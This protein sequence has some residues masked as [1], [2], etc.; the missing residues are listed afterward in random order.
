MILHRRR[1]RRTRRTHY[2]TI[3]SRRRLHRTK[4]F[5]TRVQSDAVFFVRLS[6]P[7]L[8]LKKS[9]KKKQQKKGH[10]SKTHKTHKRLSPPPPPPL[11]SS[12]S[13]SSSSLLLS[14]S[15]R[16]WHPH[17]P[18]RPPCLPR[19]RARVA[20]PLVEDAIDRRVRRPRLPRRHRRRLLLLVAFVVEIKRARWLRERQNRIGKSN[21]ENK[22]R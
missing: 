20:S 3:H 5:G 16:E 21:R 11:P 17:S 19:R 12:S 8:S 2:Q 10:F 15:C 7:S 22:T 4:E 9:K 14:S 6:L 18:R 1:R 13:S